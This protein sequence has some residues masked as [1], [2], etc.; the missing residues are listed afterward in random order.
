MVF[1][2]VC[3]AAAI[4]LISCMMF[5]ASACADEDVKLEVTSKKQMVNQITGVVYNQPTNH[6]FIQRPLVM[7]IIM[8]LGKEPH[9]TILYI[10]GGGF[11]YSSA[12]AYIQ[13]RMALAERGYVVAS[14]EYR[15]APAATFPAP[16]EDA[17]AAVRFLRANAELFCI[18]KNKIGVLGASAGGYLAA[19]LGA[20]NGVSGFDKGN[21]LGES[22]DVQAVAD[23]YGVSDITAVGA[24]FGKEEQKRFHSAG[25]SEALLING[26]TTYGGIDGGVLA[27][28]EGA[29]AANPM[30]YISEKTPPF[31][32]MHGDA[33]KVVSPSQ[34]AILRDAL[35]EHG[36]EVKRYVLTG[37][38][39]GGPAWV[40]PEV[41]KVIIDFFDSH[42]K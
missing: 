26:T 6:G 16:V 13:Q 15:V 14:I 8:P 9:P 28:P 20:T 35:K 30:T 12:S 5:A 33:D 17:K 38:G 25:A 31:L 18:D 4:A 7:D 1:N 23:V 41:M 37:V 39:H 21:F 29:K 19:M 3:R 36:I 24:D 10:C 40:Q 22:S 11:V 34:S 2:P 27:N 32:L 42:L